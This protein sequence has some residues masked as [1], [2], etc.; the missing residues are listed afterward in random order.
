M[1]HPTTAIWSWT[2]KQGPRT[3]KAW[4]CNLGDRFSYEV[5]NVTCGMRERLVKKVDCKSLPEA[6][7]EVF[8]F[9]EELNAKETL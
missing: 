3:F 9:F 5:C 2:H 8:E 7:A 4:V 6:K 1:N